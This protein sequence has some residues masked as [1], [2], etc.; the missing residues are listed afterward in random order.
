MRS[1]PMPEWVLIFMAYLPGNAPT[2]SPPS[3]VQIVQVPMATESA[4]KLA[5]EEMG[6]QWVRM[7]NAWNQLQQKVQGK[8]KTAAEE[9][10]FVDSWTTVYSSYRCYSTR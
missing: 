6:P 9:Q 8:P 10:K 3:T 1:W 7:S 5:G 4:C 2:H